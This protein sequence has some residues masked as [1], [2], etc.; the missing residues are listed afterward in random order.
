[1]PDQLERT[2]A[3]VHLLARVAQ[4]R[5]IDGVD[6]GAALRVGLLQEAAQRLVRGLQ[7]TTQFVVHPGQ[8]A[9]VVGHLVVASSRTC[10]IHL[11]FEFG[12][13]GG[14]LSVSRS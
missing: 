13:V 3:L 10:A 14:A 7:R 8:C 11:G 9:Q 12:T 4:D 2:D 1:M 5:R 6:V